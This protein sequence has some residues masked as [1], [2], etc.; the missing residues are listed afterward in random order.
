MT[1]DDLEA[2]VDAKGLSG[3]LNMLR[4]ICNAKAEKN[5]AWSWAANRIERTAL[6]LP[7]LGERS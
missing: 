3:V 2:L 7:Y 1:H 6:A 5:E 4:H